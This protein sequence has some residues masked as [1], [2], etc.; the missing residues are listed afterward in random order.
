MT[1]VEP[2]FGCRLPRGAA[3]QAGDV[4]VMSGEHC[5]GYTWLHEVL[6]DGSHLNP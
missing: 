4:T 1:I 2:V 3:S 5:G 6:A